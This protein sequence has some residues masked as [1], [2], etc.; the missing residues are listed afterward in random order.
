MAEDEATKDWRYLPPR[1]LASIG[2]EE[3]IRERVFEYRKWYDS[4]AVKAK[5]RYQLMR[6]V[7]VVGAAVVPVLVNYNIPEEFEWVI[8]VLTTAISLLVV[9]LVSLESVFH[10]GDQWKNYRS[11]EQFLAQEYF[12]FTSGEGPYR[13]MEARDAFLDFVERI[14]GAIASENASTLKVLTVAS[15][16]K[17]RKLPTEANKV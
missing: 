10:F 12:Q 3:Y 6:G 11:T 17:G 16:S 1:Q 7:S 9:I 4:S 2:P 15:D 13:D 14:E 5:F 8:R